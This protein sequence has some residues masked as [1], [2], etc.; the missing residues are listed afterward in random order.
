VTK[1]ILTPQFQDQD[2]VLDL[3]IRKN[4]KKID[5]QVDL[6]IDNKIDPNPILNQKKEED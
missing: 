6:K 4:L 2:L 3:R 1:E 5:Q